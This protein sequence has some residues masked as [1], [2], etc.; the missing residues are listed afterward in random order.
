MKF[1]LTTIQYNK[2]AHAENRTVPRV[3]ETLDN[4][5]Q[6]FH[7]QVGKDMKNAT[8]GGSLNYV[9]NSLGGVYP[10]L[11]KQWGFMEEEVAE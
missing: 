9:T 6:A 3:F 1:Y 10:N 5:E 8:L 2:E 4:A 7:E 11:N